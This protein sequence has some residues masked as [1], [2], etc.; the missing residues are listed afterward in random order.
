MN[1]NT[2]ITFIT[3]MNTPSFITDKKGNVIF[4]NGSMRYIC[5][6]IG[7]KDISHVDK[8]AIVIE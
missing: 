3:N 4:S 7:I 5:E 8:I 6:K 2:I 1:K